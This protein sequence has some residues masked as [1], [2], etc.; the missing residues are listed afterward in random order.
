MQFDP[1]L[2]I[3][4]NN[5]A[6]DLLVGPPELRDPKEALVLARKAVE[7]SGDDPH[8]TKTLGVA[9]YR[10]DRFDEAVAVL[11]KC[12]EA[13]KD[14]TAAIDLFFLA[15]CRHRLGDA[16]AAKK[17]RDR[18]VAWVRDNGKTLSAVRSDELAAFQTEADGVLA[19]APGAGD[20]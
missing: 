20:K 17:D 13:S 4:N 5:L 7:R 10:N 8:Q 6:W 1:D 12:A 11:E 9:L 16:D 3:A 2:A 19:Q 14:E 18:A 15:M